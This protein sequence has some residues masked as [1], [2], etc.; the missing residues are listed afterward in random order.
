MRRA[1]AETH[2]GHDPAFSRPSPG[3]SADA[4][5]RVSSDSVGPASIA[6]TPREREVLALAADHYMAKEI[7][8]R[9]GLSAANVGQIIW[10]A[11]QKFGAVSRG[12][13]LRRARLMGI[14]S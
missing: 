5:T 12:E 9:L 2:A 6:L 11:Q 14:H 4:H 8:A 13:M 10:R 7:A 1:P 3:S